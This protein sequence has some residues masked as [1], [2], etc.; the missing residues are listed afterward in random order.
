M[1]APF[2]ALNKHPS[3]CLL[4]QLASCALK[5]PTKPDHALPC[6]IDHSLVFNSQ[7]CSLQCPMLPCYALQMPS[8]LHGPSKPLSGATMSEVIRNTA[9][10]LQGAGEPHFAICI[11]VVGWFICNRQLIERTPKLVS[12]KWADLPMTRVRVVGWR[13]LS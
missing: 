9:S 12:P 1:H 3:T 11:A 5:C 13:R 6:P 10:V 4:W 2:S 8:H 7:V